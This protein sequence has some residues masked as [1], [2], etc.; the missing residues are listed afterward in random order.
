MDLNQQ[1]LIEDEYFKALSVLVDLTR[2]ELPVNHGLCTME[3]KL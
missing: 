2:K 1:K 3:L